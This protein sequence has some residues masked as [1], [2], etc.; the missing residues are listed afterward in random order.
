VSLL[1]SVVFLAAAVAAGVSI[2]PASIP[3]STVAQV[4]AGHLP[5]V[6]SADVSSIDGQILW[7]VRM[8]RVALAGVVG[9]MLAGSGAAYQGVF[10]NPL[11]DPYLLG[12][13]A[14]AGLGATAVIISGGAAALLTPAAFVGAL[15]AVTLT[16]LLGTSAARGNAPGIAGSTASIVLAGVAVASMFTAVQTYLQQ[17]HVDTVQNVYA[18]LLGRLTLASW[19]EVR[20]ALPYAAVT[21]LVL[22]LHAR[23]LD[24]LRVG[25]AEA[26]SLGISTTRL[27]LVVVAAATIG[28]AAAVSVSGLIGFVGIIVPHALRLTA[29]AS[30]RLLLPVAMICGAAFLILADVVARTV[31][32]P[33]E[34]P[35]GV[36]TA[37]VGAPFFL[38]VLRSRRAREQLS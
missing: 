14:G 33:A 24:V 28:T 1:V 3:L 21:G 34:I 9:A 5:F 2:G 10:R 18:W 27:R 19:S 36:V 35:I 29:G 25:E 4:L 8:P 37:C 11:A 32:A 38:F 22:L 17:R 20:T 16:Y 26:A 15:A 13:S 12:I 23:Q 31:Q 30:Y 7:Q 6:S